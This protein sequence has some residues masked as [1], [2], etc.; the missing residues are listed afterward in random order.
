MPSHVHVGR[1]P[2]LCPPRRSRSEP[3]SSRR[4][5]Q[6]LNEVLMQEDLTWGAGQVV[7]DVTCEPAE[8]PIVE[9]FEVKFVSGP[10]IP[11]AV[12]V[13]QQMSR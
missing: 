1:I 13:A 4:A 2:Q 7:D 12:P 11:V 8:K 5:P 10:A 9:A 3:T 6:V